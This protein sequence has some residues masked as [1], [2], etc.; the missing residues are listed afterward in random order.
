MGSVIKRVHA[1]EILDSRGN[2]TVEVHMASS[3]FCAKAAVP[4]GAST[5]IHEAVELR[6]G[7]KRYG[8]KGVLK[9]VKNVNQLIA[10][11]I[12]GM[13]CRKQKEI[14]DKLLELDGTENKSRLGANAILAVS[15]AACKLGAKA[16]DKALY[17]HIASLAETK[18]M[19][20]PLPQLNVI[21]GGK[22]AGI[23]NDIQ[24]HM[25]V[26]SGFKNF[27]EALR[28]S[29][30]TYHTL[31]G[32]LKKKFGAIAVDLGDEG[33]FVPPVKEINERLTL[34]THAIGEAGY[35]KKIK[36]A[37]D[38]ASSE[39]YKNGYYFIGKKKYD[40]ASL[41]DFY[42]DLTKTY[43]VVSIEDGMAQD[44]WD[45]WQL[46][47]K[48]LGK[49]LQIVGDDLL[50]TNAERI[51]K[52]INLSAAN[53]LLL[54]V[55]QIGTI[56]EAIDAF[57]LA[58]KNKWN[59]VVSHRSGETED[60]FIADLAVGLDAS[61]SKFGAPARSER[62]AKYNRLLHIEESLGKKARF[63]GK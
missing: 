48:K 20:L 25:L 10:K 23:E 57:K 63:S 43:P 15:M 34:L 19:T 56:S 16:S 46:L 36:L 3:S 60:T 39:F 61:Q 44:D 38:A 5:G 53:A 59:T 6:D 49:K 31:K 52:A 37:I 7:G 17:G 8:G 30:E 62:T 14:D 18:G 58:D 45:G 32:I 1:L 4:S 47:N 22:H 50:V 35:G 54:K 40:S 33:G 21:N 26:P 41:A 24:E 28:A 11:K 42:S 2:P 51:K 9:A 12:S 55:N 27:H 29:V 13:D